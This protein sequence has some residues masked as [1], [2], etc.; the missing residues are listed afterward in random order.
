MLQIKNISKSFSGKTILKDISYIFPEHKRIALIGVNGAGKTTLLNIL[1]GLEEYDKGEPL[2]QKKFALEP[3]DT[4]ESVAQ[5]IHH[6]EYKYFPGV[7][8][9][10]IL[11]S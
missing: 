11:S 2:F 1:C 5:K 10:Y 6:L 3:G 7:V 8:E 9:K 4:A